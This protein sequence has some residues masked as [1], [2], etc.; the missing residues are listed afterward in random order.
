MTARDVPRVGAQV[1]LK[2]STNSRGH[3]VQPAAGNRTLAKCSPQCD[4]LHTARK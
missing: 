1:K 4:R 3:N 2:L